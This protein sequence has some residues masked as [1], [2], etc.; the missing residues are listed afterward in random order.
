MAQTVKRLPAMQETWVRFLGQEDPLEKE[1]A[2]HSSTLAWKILSLEEPDRLQSMGSQRVAHD[3]AWAKSRIRLTSLH[4][5]MAA[6]PFLP[7][8][9]MTIQILLHRKYPWWCQV[10]QDQEFWSRARDS[11]VLGAG[12]CAC[13]FPSVMSDSFATPWIVAHQVPLSMGFS[14]QEYWSALPCPPP[15]DFPDPGIKPV[16]PA[17]PALQAGPL[18]LSHQKP[19]AGAEGTK[20][21]PSPSS[22]SLCRRCQHRRRC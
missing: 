16:S 6:M 11:D 1:M 2:I 8:D 17:A 15:G 7:M 13:S 19:Y 12:V 5:R 3:W 21:S 20:T 22:I 9:S 10:A 18:L 4:L 14:Q